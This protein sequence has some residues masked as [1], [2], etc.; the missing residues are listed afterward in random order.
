MSM[1]WCLKMETL[2]KTRERKGK[3]PVLS[4]HFDYGNLSLSRYHTG[5]EHSVV[6]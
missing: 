1:K 5:C 4:Q 3:A 2:D 6:N